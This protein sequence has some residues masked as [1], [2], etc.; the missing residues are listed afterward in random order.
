MKKKTFYGTKSIKLDGAKLGAFFGENWPKMWLQLENEKVKS[1]MSPCGI[2]YLWDEKTMVTE[3]V[4]AMCVPKGF[5]LKGWEK[6]SIPATKVLSVPYY[7]A[8]EKSIEAHYA[9][10]EYL[11]A[12]KLSYSFVIE[13]YVT[14]PTLQ[15][16]TAKWLT[17]IY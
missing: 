16:D 6:Y 1:T 3:C 14:D 11:K 17:N 8:P 10:D 13:E 5:E 12:N 7:G 4:A 9:M 2:L 15:K